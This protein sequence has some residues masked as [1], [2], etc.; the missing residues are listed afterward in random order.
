VWI[1]VPHRRD[2]KALT[3]RLE[4]EGLQPV[5]RWRY[6]FVGAE[7]ED[8]AKQLAD[9]LRPEVPEGST[10]TVEGTFATVERNNPF[11]V[12]GAFTGEP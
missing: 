11:A 12:F 10:L 5:R 8:A 1:D 7:D 6:V 4:R 2:A 3:E 9:R